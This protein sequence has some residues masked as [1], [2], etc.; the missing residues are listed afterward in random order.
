M[1]AD[2]TLLTGDSIRIKIRSAVTSTKLCQEFVDRVE[3]LNVSALLDTKNLYAI[4]DLCTGKVTFST[5]ITPTISTAQPSSRPSSKPTLTQS[6]PPTVAMHTSVTSGF[7]GFICMI[8]LI[9]FLRFHPVI[10]AMLAKKKDLKVGNLYDILVVLNED[11]EAIIE[12][13]RHED[14]AFFR[15]TVAKDNN[16]QTLVW[17]MNA[18]SDAL[19]KR[20]EVQFFDQF[21][22]LGESGLDAKENHIGH[23]VVGDKLVT[24]EIYSHE[25]KL[26]M[27]MIIRVKLP[28]DE[29]DLKYY[30]NGGSPES[31][32]L[33]SVPDTPHKLKSSKGSVRKG[34]QKSSRVGVT[35]I[36]YQ[37]DDD[38]SSDAG[39]TSRSLVSLRALSRP[40]QDQD[41]DRYLDSARSN[42][43]DGISDDDSDSYIT[44]RL[45]Q[46]AGFEYGL[47]DETYAA[48]S[49]GEDSVNSTSI[50]LPLD[51]LSFSD[52]NPMYNSDGNRSHYSS[53]SSQRMRKRSDL[54]EEKRSDDDDDADDEIVRA[55]RSSRRRSDYTVA[56]A[57]S[58][59]SNITT[60]S[61]ESEGSK[62]N[63]NFNRPRSSR[64]SKKYTFR[65]DS[66][67][68]VERMNLTEIILSRSQS[69]ST[70]DEVRSASIKASRRAL[71]PKGSVSPKAVVRE[72]SNSALSEAS[73]STRLKV[74]QQKA[75]R[76]EQMESDWQS[77]T[78]SMAEDLSKD[79]FDELQK[80]GRSE[81]MESDWKSFT[82]SMAEDLS[83]D[84]VD[85]LQKAG[86]SEQM[87]SDWKSFTGSMAENLAKDRFD[88]LQC[89]PEEEDG[90]EY[91]D[92][93]S[94]ESKSDDSESISMDDEEISEMGS[95]WGSNSH[96]DMH[97]EV[98]DAI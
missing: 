29:I 62:S 4:T 59:I 51:N 13:V 69:N 11:E 32:D 38:E 67:A 7:I 45:S 6:S 34:S 85:E 31:S 94:D 39:F 97:Y 89:K 20:F 54:V 57:T 25:A 24:K 46:K 92:R 36:G 66:V 80:A 15:R 63:T 16:I 19:E 74:L 52:I 33:E 76:S 17:M 30:N 10:T 28:P 61:T 8:L 50:D 42:Y 23:A 68:D 12:N 58:L 5:I 90:G 79:R 64:G 71:S 60:I 77:F 49:D 86:R 2:A 18:T 44:P 93:D 14:I 82:G 84:R 75:G 35:P 87:E 96:S 70:V 56:S 27:G 98:E 55:S 78:A 88:K 48:D 81:Q 72:L 21:D 1:T 43:D 47:K 95:R 3:Y 41:V 9:A 65:D 26:H 73:T 37:D 83:K 22:L 53:R 91:E 40:S